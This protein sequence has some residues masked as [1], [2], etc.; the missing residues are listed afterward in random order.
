[1][2]DDLQ[3]PA[4][5]PLVLCA[6]AV[7]MVAALVIG[8]GCGFADDDPKPARQLIVFKG[9]F[10]TGDLSQWTWGAQCANTGVPSSGSAVRGTIS[11]QSEIV[12]QG[13]N[14][15]R[16]D[17]PAASG[18]SACETLSKRTIDIGADDYYGLMVRFPSGWREPSHVGWGL[19]IAQLNFQNIWGAP[20]ILI[21]H[22]NH[23]ALVLQSGLCNSAFTSRPGCTHSSGPGGNVKPMVAVPAPLAT[24]AWHELIIHVRWAADSSGVLEAWHRLKGSGSWNKTAFLSG[25][26]TVQW[27]S[28]RGLR[29]IARSVTSDKVGAYRG[30]ADFPLTVWHD[31]FVRAKSFSVAASPLP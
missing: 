16:I 19:S 1:M 12:G 31:G 29:G 22:A 7:L 17:L 27:T 20:V 28:D 8:M 23:I 21:A 9:D 5:V 10:E 18:T 24:D 13:K 11:V 25:Y 2:V 26:P 3:Y 4:D 14:G 15:A 30:G 6:M